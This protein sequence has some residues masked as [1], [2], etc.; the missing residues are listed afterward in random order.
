MRLRFGIP[1]TLLLLLAISAASYAID[2]QVYYPVA[3]LIAIACAREARRLGLRGY[4][5]A[6]A[7]PALPLIAVMVFLLPLVLP[8]FLKVRHLIRSGQMAP[9]PVMNRKWQV[10]G[11]VL[12]ALIPAY[13][14]V[15]KFMGLP[16]AGFVANI[17]AVVNE[18]N[19]TCGFVGRVTQKS[20]GKLTITVNGDEFGSEARRRPFARR[21]AAIAHAAHPE[22]DGIVTIEVEFVEVTER[23]GTTLT[24]SFARYSWPVSEVQVQRESESLE[25]TDDSVSRRF[26]D[27]FFTSDRAGIAMMHPLADS[28]APG[29]D[30]V[31]EFV[32]RNGVLGN[33]DST[34]LLTCGTYHEEHGPRKRT[35]RV[36]IGPGNSRL[37]LWLTGAET[38]T[39]VKSL[40]ITP[41]PKRDSI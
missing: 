4:P 23:G 34:I 1:L 24:K 5:T 31:Q 18:L 15:A 22:R 32:A 16:A 37:E 8:W 19:R 33:P 36:Y 30:R 40:R 28:A 17:Q 2:Y 21:V 14:L 26:A 13:F 38:E 9:G 27:L 29:W 41:A 12:V 35:Y 7:L 11:A 10:V 39:G 20:G 25:A 3:A 6:L